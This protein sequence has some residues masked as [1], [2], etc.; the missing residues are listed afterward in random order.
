M[1]R[2]IAAFLLAQIVAHSLAVE[3]EENRAPLAEAIETAF[4]PVE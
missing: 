2:S 1:K 3:T 4:A